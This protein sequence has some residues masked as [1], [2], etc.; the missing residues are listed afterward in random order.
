MHAK[1][2]LFR[3]LPDGQPVWIKA[4]AG[5]E[6]AKSELGQIARSLPG[7]YFIFDTGNASVIPAETLP[8]CEAS[9]RFGVDVFI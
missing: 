2:D 1:Y 4:V 7:D 3:K 5:L 6:E 8:L 9:P